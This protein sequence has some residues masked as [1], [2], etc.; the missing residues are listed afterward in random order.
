MRTKNT[1]LMIIYKMRD[2]KQDTT[3]NLIK[4]RLNKDY[5]DL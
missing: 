5:V 2:N 3:E 1:M 4:K